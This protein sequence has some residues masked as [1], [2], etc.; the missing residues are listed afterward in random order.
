MLGQVRHK[1]PIGR[2]LGKANRV[3]I[4]GFLTTDFAALGHWLAPSVVRPGFYIAFRQVE[5]M[6]RSSVLNSRNALQ[7]QKNR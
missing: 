4:L 1:A 2:S 7:A 3:A 5:K 6:I